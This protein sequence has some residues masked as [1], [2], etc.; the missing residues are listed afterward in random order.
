MNLKISKENK[1]CIVCFIWT[2]WLRYEVSM[3][4]CLVDYAANFLLS[5]LPLKYWVVRLSVSIPRLFALLFLEFSWIYIDVVFRTTNSFKYTCC[6]CCY[7]PS[8]NKILLL[9]LKRSSISLIWCSRVTESHRRSQSHDSMV[10]FAIAI[11]LF[12]PLQCPIQ[13]YDSL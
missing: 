12:R 2:V 8:Q 13:Q 10:C 1:F 7:Y 4:H 3:R 11:G 5:W 6:N 9:I